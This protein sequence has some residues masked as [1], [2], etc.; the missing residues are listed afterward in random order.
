MKT[1]I[2]LAGLFS[3]FFSLG[4]QAETEDEIRDSSWLGIEFVNK[5]YYDENNKLELPD[6][7]VT[8][9]DLKV[10]KLTFEELLEHFNY[11]PNRLEQAFGLEIRLS[12]V[13]FIVRDLISKELNQIVEDE[14]DRLNPDPTT[15]IREEIGR[16]VETELNDLLA[17]GDGLIGGLIPEE[18]DALRE[19]VTQ[20]VTEQVL[21]PSLNT[22]TYDLATIPKQQ[23]LA[24]INSRLGDIEDDLAIQNVVLRF[25]GILG[26][27][28]N[29]L[30]FLRAGKMTLESSARMNYAQQTALG[31]Y[32]TQKSRTQY[33]TGA[34]GSLGAHIGYVQKLNDETS[35][36]ADVYVF[37]NKMPYITYQNY[38]AN[39]AVMDDDEYE[40]QMHDDKINSELI[41]ILFNSKY[42]D[43][44]YATGDY[45]G[46]E[47]QAMGLV[48]K[49]PQ[50]GTKLTLDSYEGERIVLKQGR[51]LGISQ[52]IPLP[53][54][55]ESWSLVAYGGQESLE[56]SMQRINNFYNDLDTEETFWGVKLGKEFSFFRDRVHGKV[57]LHF[58][59]YDKDSFDPVENNSTSESGY[60][61]GYQ[62]E[63]LF[64]GIKH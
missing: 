49:I 37:H 27:S 2:I 12:G 28:G 1:L 48:F 50:T 45:D 23:A 64:G 16:T 43:T 15:Q 3:F 30:V 26:G 36:Q 53:F 19:Q 42:I 57:G 54:L 47:A 63:L 33:A 31:E 24:K 18:V 62:L 52:K 58:E 21:G 10:G 51:I 29:S 25:S 20:Q 41:R 61:A 7:N 22:L 13:P 6:V 5:V 8:H 60:R 44:F 39:Y 14:A 34:T 11:A 55:D 40:N 4:L 38:L 17:Q 56:G 9:T 35:V 59:T 46:R 32:R